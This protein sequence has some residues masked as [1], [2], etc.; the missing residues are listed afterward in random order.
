MT[1]RYR[2]I[3]RVVRTHGRRGEV[4][5]EALR[6]LPFVVRTGLEVALTPPALKRDRFMTVESV[7]DQ[8][9][10]FVVAFAGIDSLT[11]A[12]DIVGC[13]LLAREDDLDLG[14]LEVSLDR[15]RGREVID[16]RF[17]SLGVLSDIMETP[18]NDVWVVEGG[19][20][21]EVLIPVIDDAIDAIP[22]DGPLPVHI[23]DGLI[24][25]SSRG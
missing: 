5:A 21:G 1:V 2:N 25:T 16:E 6:G 12:V 17:G 4:V 9:D 13:Y 18:A 24:D 10:Q 15:L 23:M 11:A 19:P 7:R 20:Y 3:A 14:A 8:G 22:D